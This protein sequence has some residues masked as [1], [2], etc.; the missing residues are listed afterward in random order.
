MR[1]SQFL[2]LHPY[3]DDLMDELDDQI[4]GLAER[5]IT[6]DGSPVATLREV[7]NAFSR[8]ITLFSD[9]I[10]FTISVIIDSIKDQLLMCFCLTSGYWSFCFGVKS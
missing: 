7:D 4:D 2:K 1:G 5:L 10:I 3:L 8:A 9:L 6:I